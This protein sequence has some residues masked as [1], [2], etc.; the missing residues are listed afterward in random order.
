MDKVSFFYPVNELYV[1]V[2]LS[3]EIKKQI[4]Y[5]LNAKVLDPYQ[6][7][8]LKEEL[9]QHKIKYLLEK[10]NFGIELLVFSKDIDKLN[11]LVDALKNYE[12]LASVCWFP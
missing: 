6:L 11:S 4:T 7:F 5:K 3:E 10:N 2:E 12:I 9:K 1:K 8:C